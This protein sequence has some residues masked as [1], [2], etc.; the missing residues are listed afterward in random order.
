MSSATPTIDRVALMRRAHLIARRCIKAAILG[1]HR[2][3]DRQIVMG[4]GML[5]C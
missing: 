1:I 5:M 2:M 3:D 4:I